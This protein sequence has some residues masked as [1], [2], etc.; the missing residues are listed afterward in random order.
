LLFSFRFPSSLL[1]CSSFSFSFS[2]SCSFLI[3]VLFSSMVA[4]VH[5]AQTLPLTRTHVHPSIRWILDMN[6]CSKF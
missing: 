4:S 3:L 2:F 5:A 6:Q 1:I